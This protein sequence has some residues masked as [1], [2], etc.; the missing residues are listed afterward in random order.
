MVLLDKAMMELSSLV[1]SVTLAKH[2]FWIAGDGNAVGELTS[3]NLAS[4]S[5]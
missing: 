2:Q 4:S 5:S 1:A 3:M